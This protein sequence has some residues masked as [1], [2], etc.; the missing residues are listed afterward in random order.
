LLNDIYYTFFETHN[1]QPSHTKHNMEQ[2]LTSST[3]MQDSKSYEQE[4]F[5][6]Q[7][8]FFLNE[9]LYYSVHFS[10]TAR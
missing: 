3:R 9:T 5:P 8:H 6:L 1:V 2:T 7:M 4:S 10:H